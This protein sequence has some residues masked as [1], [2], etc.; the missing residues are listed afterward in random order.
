MQDSIINEPGM[1]GQQ[2]FKG[3]AEAG[4]IGRMGPGVEP[5][6][7]LDAAGQGRPG[8]VGRA[9]KDFLIIPISEKIGLGVEGMI[10]NIVKAQLQLVTEAIFKQ[11]EGDRLGD[12]EIIAAENPDRH[13]PGRGGFK[14]LQ[15]QADAGHH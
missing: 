15:H 4:A 10:G 8:Q 5:V 11:I 14:I 2:S 1:V 3:L 7:P 6:V 12:I 13:A 9:D